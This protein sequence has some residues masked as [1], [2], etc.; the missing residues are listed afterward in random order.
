[1]LSGSNILVPKPS[2]GIMEY[3]TLD[4][5]NPGNH[6]PDTQW[7]DAIGV[8]RAFTRATVQ[9]NWRRLTPDQVRLLSAYDVTQQFAELFQ[10]IRMPALPP[11]GPLKQEESNAD[12][13]LYTYPSNGL[14]Y[15]V[16]QDLFRAP[17]VYPP[18][19]VVCIDVKEQATIR[20]WGWEANWLALDNWYCYR[21][22]Y[23]YLMEEV[24]PQMVTTT[25][26]RGGKQVPAGINSAG[27]HPQ[28][29][30]GRSK[31]GYR[32]LR[33]SII[34]WALAQAGSICAYTH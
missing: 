11:I 7:R 1:M 21:R 10:P 29:H 2:V 6:I 13:R 31:P 16:L 15:L 5:Q 22:K 8:D 17:P 19:A 14:G 24:L 27:H 28:C 20:K 3:T 32:M 9:E 26:D 18:H 33:Y 30:G 4:G 34:A 12:D 23:K 25:N